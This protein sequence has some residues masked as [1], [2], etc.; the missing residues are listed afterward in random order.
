V[1]YDIT[2]SNPGFVGNSDFCHQGWE[3]VIAAKIYDCRNGKLFLGK[4]HFLNFSQKT[5]GEII[6][7]DNKCD[8]MSTLQT[9]GSSRK[10]V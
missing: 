6:S 3:K 8:I 1:T 4:M 10:H 7:A 5:S 9:G 2:G